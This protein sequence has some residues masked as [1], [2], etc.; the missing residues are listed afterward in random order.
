MSDTPLGSGDRNEG[1]ILFW[2]ASQTDVK[3]KCYSK[4]KKSEE[5]GCPLEEYTILF[6]I[7]F[8]FIFFETEICSCCPGCSRIV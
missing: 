4:E 6:I 5:N 3:S 1:N 2:R 8:I 7:Y